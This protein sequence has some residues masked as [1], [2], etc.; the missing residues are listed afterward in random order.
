MTE[1]N[2]P[3]SPKTHLCPGFLGA[4]SATEE[5]GAELA[6]LLVGDA[7]E[8]GRVSDIHIDPQADCYRLRFRL[9]GQLYAVAEIPRSVGELLVR[10]IEVEAGIDSTSRNE[11]MEG[12]A[13]LGPSGTSIRVARA[14]TVQ[15]PKL[16]LRLLEASRIEHDIRELGMEQGDLNELLEWSSHAEGMLLCVGPTGCGKTTTAYSLLNEMKPDRNI[17]TL[18]D[19]VEFALEGISQIA[20]DRDNPTQPASFAE[21]VH[22]L[23]RHDPDTLFLGEIRSDET[24]RAAISASFSGHVLLSTMHSRDPAGA[25]TLLRSMGV[26]DYEIAASLKIIV[27]QRVLRKLC[28]DCRQQR[29]AKPPE[30]EAAREQG[31]SLDQVW[32][33]PGC[34]QC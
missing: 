1:N 26:K 9:D 32:D 20:L 6:N 7:L 16:S 27:G 25:I 12:S 14:L 13:E 11:R 28:G 4:V 3:N 23:L 17:L 15:G 30:V 22:D 31:V 8:A 21:G 18:E 19:P 5:D 10:S 33:A 34:E 2:S 24:A 29:A